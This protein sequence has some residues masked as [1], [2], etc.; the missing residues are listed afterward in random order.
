[1]MYKT[2]NIKSTHDAMP[3]CVT[4]DLNCAGCGD[5][6]TCVL[7]KAI[8]ASET[9]MPPSAE[10]KEKLKENEKKKKQKEKNKESRKERADERQS[11]N[12]RENPSWRSQDV[13]WFIPFWNQQRQQWHARLPQ[14]LFLTNEQVREL[15]FRQADY[16]ID[17]VRQMVI[18][19]MRS[20]YL[21]CRT[22]KR[23]RNDLD[24][25]LSAKFFPRVA[26]GRYN[27]LTIEERPLTEEE[28][29][30]QE[31]ERR[32]AEREA[33]RRQWREEEE[34]RSRQMAQQREAWA[35]GAVSYEEYQRMKQN[36]QIE[37]S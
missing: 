29:R 17:K 26:Q 20:D 6:A 32:A 36:G 13:D 33:L 18:N 23:A 34:K 31:A 8:V 19:A 5:A 30:K 7:K 4:C 35:R 9:E 28:R 27:D 37:T 14:V 11:V 1:M 25:L 12:V 22:G 2:R 10:S 24:F 3:S 15:K 16:G 21:N